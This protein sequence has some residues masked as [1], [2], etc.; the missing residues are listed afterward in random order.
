[1]D[2]I[3][4]GRRGLATLT[5]EPVDYFPFLTPN[6]ADLVIAPL[7]RCIYIEGK[8]ELDQITE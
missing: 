6:E 8:E 3:K 5:D 1:L 2:I 7:N 4:T